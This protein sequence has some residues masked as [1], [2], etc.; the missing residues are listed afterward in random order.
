MIS[1]YTFPN[2]DLVQ[3][4][5]VFFLFTY[6]GKH[7]SSFSFRINI[8][9]LLNIYMHYLV[10]IFDQDIWIRYIFSGFIIVVNLCT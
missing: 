7:A 2:L 3:A 10:Q 8:L 1:E 9:H 5:V 6:F 4:I